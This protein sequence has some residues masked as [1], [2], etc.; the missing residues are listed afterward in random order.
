MTRLLTAAFLTTLAL[1]STPSLAQEDRAAQVEQRIEEA[2][3]RL[4]LTDEQLDQMTPV[5]E[6]SMAARQSILSSYG[7][8]LENRSGSA[9][10]LGLRQARAMR[11][12]LDV[13]QAD[14]L[15][16]LGRILN[17]EQME[18]FKRMQEERKAEMRERILGRRS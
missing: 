2:K 10:K 3:A 6:E 7:I 5:L 16:A 8:D 12:E 14:T 9:K 18:E 13:V 17:D 11:K 1:V 15:D 4:N